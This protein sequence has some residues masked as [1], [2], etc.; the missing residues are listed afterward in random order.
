MERIHD[1]IR[2]LKNLILDY[3]RY[4]TSGN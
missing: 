3:I 1:K 2:S 4:L